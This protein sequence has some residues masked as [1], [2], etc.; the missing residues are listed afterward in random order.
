MIDQGDDALQKLSWDQRITEHMAK[1]S[2]EAANNPA[3]TRRN[4]PL[5]AQIKS[6][7]FWLTF[8]A[9]GAAFFVFDTAKHGWVYA[10]AGVLYL[11]ALLAGALA[12]RDA[13]TASLARVSTTEEP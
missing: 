9:T 12:R 5:R 8:V 6:P 11:G 13:R 7:Y 1:Q 2:W 10:I 4:P 3:G